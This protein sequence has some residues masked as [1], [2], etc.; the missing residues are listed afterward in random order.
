MFEAEIFSAQFCGMGLGL[1]RRVKNVWAK[2]LR[3]GVE[4]KGS[5]L[6]NAK[7]SEGLGFVALHPCRGS[8]HSNLM[9]LWQDDDGAR[10][11]SRKV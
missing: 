1:D 10:C 8:E 3:C 5:E 11:Q 6:C 9:K 7:A 2:D 4:G